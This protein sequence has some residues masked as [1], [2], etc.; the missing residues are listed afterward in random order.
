MNQ[1]FSN[2]FDLADQFV[3]R[4]P[5]QWYVTNICI[6]YSSVNTHFSTLKWIYQQH[7]GGEI[8]K[9][10]MAIGTRLFQI[11]QALF[12]HIEFTLNS[13]SGNMREAICANPH[14]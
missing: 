11:F 4:L 2:T 3:Q 8:C 13:Y 10:P 9:T 7:S 14:K 1:A 6:K 5:G 12:F